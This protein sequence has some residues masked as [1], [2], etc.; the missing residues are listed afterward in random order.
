MIGNISKVGFSYFGM[1]GLGNAEGRMGSV[2]GCGE[3]IA[4]CG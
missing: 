2:A 1:L 3:P 4:Y